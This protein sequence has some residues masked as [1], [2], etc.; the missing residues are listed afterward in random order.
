MEAAL[1]WNRRKSLPMLRGGELKG[2]GGRVRSCDETNH[3]QKQLI[4]LCREANGM[5]MGKEGGG[6]GKEGYISWC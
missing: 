6:N 5:R 4:K 1:A 2:R 3:R